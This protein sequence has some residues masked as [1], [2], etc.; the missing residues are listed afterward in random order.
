[1]NISLTPPLER[2]VLEQVQSGAYRSASEVVRDELRLL[3]ER[4]TVDDLKLAALRAAIK[5]GLG[6]GP[7]EPFDMEAIITEARAGYQRPRKS[8]RSKAQ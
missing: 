1:M 7:A 4:R 2:F 8:L 3:A 6:S 5:D